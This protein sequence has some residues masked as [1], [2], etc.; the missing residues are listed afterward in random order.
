[1]EG[2]L[3]AVPPPATPGLQEQARIRE[4][5][6]NLLQNTLGFWSGARGKVVL[7]SLLTFLEILKFRQTQTGKVGLPCC[8]VGWWLQSGKERHEPWLLAKCCPSEGPRSSVAL[9]SIQERAS[10]V[11]CAGHNRPVCVPKANSSHLP[12]GAGVHCQLFLGPPNP[13][14]VKST[15]GQAGASLAQLHSPPCEP[16]ASEPAAWGLGP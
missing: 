1:M 9:P 10:C 11:A 14:C 8:W 12:C 15:L 6:G 13:Q 4:G 2:L 5:A 16:T 3:S 7:G